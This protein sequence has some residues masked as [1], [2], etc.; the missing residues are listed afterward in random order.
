MTLLVNEIGY[1]FCWFVHV[2][3]T[4][5]KSSSRLTHKCQT[6][7]WFGIYIAIKIKLFILSRLGIK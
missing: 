7:D 5:E 3:P 6:I 1:Y 2:F 4:V